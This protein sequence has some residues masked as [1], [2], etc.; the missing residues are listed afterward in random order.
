[1]ASNVW[2]YKYLDVK[3]G[4][5][6]LRNSNLQFTNATQLNDP[7]DCHPALID[8]SNV[9]VNEHNWPPASF[10]KDKGEKDMSNL[11]NRAWICSLSKLHNSVPMWA[12]YS[13]HMG[14]C[15]GLNIEK[16]KSYL[17]KIQCSFYIGAKVIEVQYRDVAEKPDYFNDS[18]D[19]F[20]YLLSTKANNWAHEQE[21]RLVLEDPSPTIMASLFKPKR[22]EVVDWKRV[23]AY[24]HIGGECFESLY[25]GIEIDKKQKE[26]VILE[27]RR[28]NP[29]IRVYKM[30][31]DTE[32]FRLKEVQ[33]L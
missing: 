17:S 18:K 1:M 11:R 3:G 6:M 21:V 19:Y 15:I 8:F 4:L 7:F 28:C 30:E 23:R 20:H 13:K 22:N 26:Q 27:A 32:A 16:A 31:V 33:V 9:P 10:L 2:L 5:A 25:L 29:N 14:V 24:P 12:Y